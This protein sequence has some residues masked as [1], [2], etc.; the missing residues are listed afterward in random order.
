MYIKYQNLT[1]IENAPIPVQINVSQ[2]IKD[3]TSEPEM[4]TDADVS[5]SASVISQLTTGATMDTQVS[6]SIIQ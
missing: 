2:I 1:E 5:V 6:K 3:I 4:L